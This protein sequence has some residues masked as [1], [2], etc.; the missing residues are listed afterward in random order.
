MTTTSKDNLN[1]A[2]IY[3]I[4]TAPDR[5]ALAAAV[6]KAIVITAGSTN[7]IPLGAPFLLS[8]PERP[9]QPEWAQA[10]VARKACP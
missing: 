5:G 3:D 6:S 1:Y 9:R 10:M 2:V 7:L 8:N 4:L